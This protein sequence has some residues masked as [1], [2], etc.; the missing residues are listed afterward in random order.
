[1][2]SILDVKKYSKKL[3]EVVLISVQKEHDVDV[4]FENSAMAIALDMS[5]SEVLNSLKKDIDK[6]VD[7]LFNV[8]KILPS[9]KNGIVHDFDS[10]ELTTIEDIFGNLYDKDKNTITLYSVEYDLNDLKQYKK[11]E[12]KKTNIYKCF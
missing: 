9:I 1:M 10:E 2:Q 3:Q 5:R 12:L 4:Y 11:T 7:S 6:S 8:Q